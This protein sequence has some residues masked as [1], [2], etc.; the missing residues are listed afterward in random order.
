MCITQYGGVI[1]HVDSS[2]L[3]ILT[4]KVTSQKCMHTMLWSV[5]KPRSGVLYICSYSACTR[6]PQLVWLRAFHSWQGL[7]FWLLFGPINLPLVVHCALYHW[8]H[9]FQSGSYPPTVWPLSV[10]TSQWLPSIGELDS[11]QITRK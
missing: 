10:Y 1:S 5:H 11:S 8:S 2:I 3:L 6:L 9:M 7:I 4:E